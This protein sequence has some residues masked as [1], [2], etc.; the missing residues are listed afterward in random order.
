[1][2]PNPVKQ[3]IALIGQAGGTI[4][5]SLSDLRE[6]GVLISLENICDD[7][8]S[9]LVLRLGPKIYYVPAAPATPQEVEP[10][11]PDQE[12]PETQRAAL[13]TLR[14][15]SRPNPVEQEMEAIQRLTNRPR[16]QEVPRA[17]ITKRMVRDVERRRARAQVPIQQVT[18][19]D[20]PFPY[21]K[22]GVHRLSDVELWFREEAAKETKRIRQRAEGN[23]RELRDGDLPFRTI[24]GR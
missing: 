22:V 5:L 13:Q 15:S 18:E 23:Q 19:Q 21:P 8:Q 12:I 24:P 1:M 20:Q 6:A 3:L 7:N 10:W 17:V 11:Q 9:K 2:I 14:T 4:S 16:P